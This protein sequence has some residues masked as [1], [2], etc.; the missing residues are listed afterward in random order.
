MSNIKTYTLMEEHTMKS[1][2][3]KPKLTIRSVNPP[4]KKKQE[5][6]IRNITKFIQETY[7]S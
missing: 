1:K 4:D 6:I 3:E 2:N 5:E 7:Y